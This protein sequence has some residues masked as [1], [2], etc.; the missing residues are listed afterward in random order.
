VRISGRTSAVIGFA[1]AIIIVGLLSALPT[2][3]RFLGGQS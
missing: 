2:V 3:L 1:S